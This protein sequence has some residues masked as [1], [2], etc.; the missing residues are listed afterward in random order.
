[1]QTRKTMGQPVHTMHQGKPVS[2]RKAVGAKQAKSAATRNAPVT[3]RKSPWEAEGSDK[4]ER[5]GGGS[6]L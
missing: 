4:D 3:M 1:M 5:A 6:Q 2:G